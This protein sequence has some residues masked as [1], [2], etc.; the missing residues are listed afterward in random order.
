MLRSHSDGVVRP[1]GPPRARSFLR[2]HADIAAPP[3]AA[4]LVPIL[5]GCHA[6]PLSILRLWPKPFAPA[7]E[8]NGLPRSSIPADGPQAETT[9]RDVQGAARTRARPK[10]G[11]DQADVPAPCG[12][13]LSR[14]SAI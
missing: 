4:D 11:L 1:Q 14:L 9:L 12:T 3:G 6:G 13:P 8:K 10:T 2:R 5:A 7:T